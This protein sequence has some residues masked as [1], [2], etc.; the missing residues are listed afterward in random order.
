[1]V[2]A[3]SR[4]I[5]L[6]PQDVKWWNSS[7]YLLQLLIGTHTHSISCIVTESTSIWLDES[8]WSQVVSRFE[9]IW[10]TTLE[11][12]I[13]I[14]TRLWPSFFLFYR[15]LLMI[16][17]SN[18][19]HYIGHCITSHLGFH[20]SVRS[21]L[22]I[23]CQNDSL[24]T[25]FRDQGIDVRKTDYQ[26]PHHLS[27]AMRKVDHLVLVVGSQIDRVT[28]ARNLCRVALRSG[29]K[30]II[31]ISHVGALCPNLE[32]SLLDYALVEDEII[33]NTDCTWTILR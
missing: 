16:L 2:W 30:S 5:F 4:I 17:I 11:K 14:Q 23:L 19:D 27:L 26:H 10:H 6:E 3:G 12:H 8:R 13:N 33:S 15:F 9:S 21:H 1:M 18:A 32:S 25:N 31:L 20:P 22:R 28:Y 7:S 24:C 29:I